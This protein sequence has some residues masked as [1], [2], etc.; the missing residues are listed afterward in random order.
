[1]AIHSPGTV[2]HMPLSLY[3]TKPISFTP[4][5]SK[6]LLLQEITPRPWHSFFNTRRTMGP[7]QRNYSHHG[8]AVVE[9]IEGLLKVHE[10]GHVERLPTMPDVP[11]TWAPE[12][13]VASRDISFNNSTGLW[14]RFHVP[15]R[16]GQLPLLVY[17][18]GGGFCIG[19]AA[20]R[21][22]HEF[23]AR[24]SSQANCL[25]MSVSY[26]L[27]PENPL[28]AAYEDGLA[29]IKWVRQHATHCTDELS[30]W[31]TKC[32]FSQM[33]VGGDSAGGAIANNVA[34]QLGLAGVPAWLKGVILIQPFFGGETRTAS[35]KNS[36]PSMRSTLSLAA[37]DCYWRLALPLGSNRDHPWCNPIAMLSS[38]KLED[39]RLPPLLVCISEMDILRD[40]N[41]E[42]CKALER[43]G[44]SVEYDVYGGV[45]HAFQVLSKSPMSQVRTQEM[46]TNIKAFIYDRLDHI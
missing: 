31:Q 13:N 39:L 4:R 28:P 37:S 12:P 20:W 9:E 14:A 17:F 22:Y 18:H 5:T 30:W 38:P 25:I 11:C 32:N 3:I 43:A 46:V 26:R 40:R 1:M 15:N 44:K 6:D 24:L 29:A 7:A 35:E 34:A 8:T 42:F 33:F 19:S 45:G 10:D 21:C 16:R 36:R 41:L 2:H 23:L 27:A